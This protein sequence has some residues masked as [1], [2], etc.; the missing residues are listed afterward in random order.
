MS[1]TQLPFNNETTVIKNM[2][3]EERTL[4]RDQWRRMLMKAE[5]LGSVKLN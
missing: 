3:D 5:N 1:Q 2:T 4:F